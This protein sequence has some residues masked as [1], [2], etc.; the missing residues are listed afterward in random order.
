MKYSEVFSNAVLAF[1]I[2]L[3]VKDAK[4]EKKAGAS[5][6]FLQDDYEKATA[7]FKKKHED[8]CKRA[9]SEGFDERVQKLYKVK[10]VEGRV[11]ACENWNGEG[12]E[13]KK[14]TDEEIAEME[15][16]KAELGDFEEKEYAQF[17]EQ[18][19]EAWDKLMDSECP[20]KIGK[21]TKEEFAEVYDLVSVDGYMDDLVNSITKE[22]LHKQSYLKLVLKN[23]V[24]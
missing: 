21:L 8:A 15:T 17:K 14:V 20:L 11:N 5:V 4:L 7:E 9:K 23:L 16:L 13:P 18:S 2:P 1:A 22:P 10:D 6:M 12:E 19:E 24:A 3:Q